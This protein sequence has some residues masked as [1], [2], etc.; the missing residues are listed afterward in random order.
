MRQQSP[1]APGPHA[2]QVFHEWRDSEGYREYAEVTRMD[3]EN[4]LIKSSQNLRALLK[5][6][7]T[8]A[9]LTARASGDKM[10]SNAEGKQRQIA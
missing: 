7:A 9:S 10:L 6:A 2:W 3:Q 4:G 5:G 8:A 1:L